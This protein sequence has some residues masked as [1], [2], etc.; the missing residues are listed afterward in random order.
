MALTVDQGEFASV[1]PFPLE[2]PEDR[3]HAQVRIQHHPEAPK[4]SYMVQAGISS[5]VWTSVL[6]S[7]FVHDSHPISRVLRFERP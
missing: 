7:K 1:G 5:G 3:P 6:G 2:V 4:Q